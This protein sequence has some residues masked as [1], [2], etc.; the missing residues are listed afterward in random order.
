MLVVYD[1]I[2]IEMARAICAAH[3]I[4]KKQRCNF[5]RCRSEMRDK[6]LGHRCSLKAAVEKTGR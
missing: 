1:T 3:E 4:A 5:T 2:I 6:E